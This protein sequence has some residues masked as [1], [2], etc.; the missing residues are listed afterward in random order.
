MC[1]EWSEHEWDGQRFLE[2]GRHSSMG[3]FQ[4]YLVR[5]NRCGRE[6]TQTEWLDLSETISRALPAEKDGAY[7]S[8]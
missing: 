2:N 3:R 1:A 8:R 6:T 5:C 7:G 4:R